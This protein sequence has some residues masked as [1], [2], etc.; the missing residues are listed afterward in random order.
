MR[1][2]R[3]N[4]RSSGISWG[5]ISYGAMRPPRSTFGSSGL[6]HGR[7]IFCRSN[8]MHNTNSHSLTS[9]AWNT[10]KGGERFWVIL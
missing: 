3:P 1:G 4:N 2:V 6:S 9:S 10:R 7:T 5:A 8:S